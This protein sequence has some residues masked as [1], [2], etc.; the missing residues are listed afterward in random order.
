MRSTLRTMLYEFRHVFIPAMVYATELTVWA[1]LNRNVHGDQ[2]WVMWRV[3]LL[4]S[5]VILFFTAI[6]FLEPVKYDIWKAAA[7]AILPWLIILAGVTVYG[8]MQM[9]FAFLTPNLFYSGV[10][11][12]YVLQFLLIFHFGLKR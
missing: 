3:F 2:E 12:S 4:I 5:L 11:A 9:N 10:L 7:G 1:V 8:L 6:L